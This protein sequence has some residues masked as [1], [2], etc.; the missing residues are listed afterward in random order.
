MLDTILFYSAVC[1]CYFLFYLQSEVSL[2]LTLCKY[3]GPFTLY[4]DML[5]VFL[6]FV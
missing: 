4:A 1:V 6:S 3:A 5:S 2:S